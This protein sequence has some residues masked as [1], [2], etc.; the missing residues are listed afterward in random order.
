MYDKSQ[1]YNSRNLLL[2]IKYIDEY[3][4]E[5]DPE[6]VLKYAEMTLYEIEDPGHWFSQEHIDKFYEK[7]VEKT[8]NIKLARDVGHYFSISPSNVLGAVKQY[9]IG[10][11]SI[12]SGFNAVVYIGSTISRGAIFKA[13]RLG[14]N[15]YEVYANVSEGVKEKPYQCMNR[16]AI[17]ESIGLLFTNSFFTV[18]HPECFHE[19]DKVCKYIVSWKDSQ[20]ILWKRLSRVLA[21]SSLLILI[22]FIPLLSFYKLIALTATCAFVSLVF[23][24]VSLKKQN[25]ELFNSIVTLGESAQD[26]MAEI[27]IRYNIMKLIQEIITEN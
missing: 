14:V 8:G 16:K 11:L 15:K 13:N 2:Y 21:V 5:V 3:S 27:N 17:L 19:G 24:S 25:R 18:D 6:E 9:I 7:L 1:L 10:M 22:F 23:I 26:L 4:P 12:S 20:A